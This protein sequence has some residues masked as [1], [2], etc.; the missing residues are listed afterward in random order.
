VRQVPAPKS[1]RAPW[2]DALYVAIR[3]ELSKYKQKR[4]AEPEEAPRPVAPGAGPGDG[5]R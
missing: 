3:N 5:T 1:G 2:V 4:E